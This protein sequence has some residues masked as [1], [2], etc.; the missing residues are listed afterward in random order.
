MALLGGHFG[1]RTPTKLIVRSA[2]L[3]VPTSLP[4]SRARAELGP[5]LLVGAD[6]EL[7][8][9]LLALHRDARELDRAPAPV[10]EHP[11][12]LA[13]LLA[14][15]EPVD[16]VGVLTGPGQI[17]TAEKTLILHRGGGQQD[18][19]GYHGS[20]DGEEAHS[21]ACYYV[22]TVESTRPFDY[23]SG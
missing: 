17:P 14:D 7:E 22:A 1:G 13:A 10:E 8:D 2:A 4:P 12:E 21:L 16:A 3:V 6:R 23:N 11:G 9:Q 15:L 18:I 5:R 20:D 19:D